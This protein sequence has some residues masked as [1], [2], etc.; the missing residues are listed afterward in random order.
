[1]VDADDG[2]IRLGVCCACGLTTKAVAAVEIKE[3]MKSGLSIMVVRLAVGI[4]VFREENLNWGRAWSGGEWQVD[5]KERCFFFGLPG[6]L[7][8]VD[9]EVKK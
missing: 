7:C 1:M 8:D 2:K 9:H 3:T 6:F 4:F 5:G